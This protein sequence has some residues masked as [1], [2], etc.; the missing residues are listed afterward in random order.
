VQVYSAADFGLPPG[1]SG[2][3]TS[4]AF[5]LDGASGQSFSGFWPGATIFLST[6]TRTPDSLSTA[7]V[8][9]VGPDSVL[10][11]SGSFVMRATNTSLFPRSFEVQVPFATPFWYDPAKGNLSMYFA[12]LGGPANLVF[13]AQ[14]SLGDGVGRVFGPNGAVSGTVDSLGFV[15]R[16]GMAVV[17][18]PSMISLAILAVA[19]IGLSRP[20][21]FRIAGRRKP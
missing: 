13:D 9:N 17:P 3:V 14:D 5:R 6:T 11:F 1:A 20:R 7:F 15:T 19:L 10:A 8:D 16:F 4:V 2:L 18:E 12:T 21:L